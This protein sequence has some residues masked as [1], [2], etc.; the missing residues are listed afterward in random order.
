MKK[1]L[2]TFSLLCS[3][4]LLHADALSEASNA[5]S[6]LGSSLKGYFG[7]NQQNTINPLATGGVISSVDGK[8]KA[9]VSLACEESKTGD[10]LNIDYTG[11]SDINI[12]MKID[13]NVDGNIDN[14]W[15]INN[16]SGICT[17]G[18]VKCNPNSWNNCKYYKYSYTGNLNIIEAKMSD[19]NSCYCINASCGSLSA[20]NKDKILND[21][22][23]YIYSALSNDTKLVVS[24]AIKSASG[25]LV[26]KG[27]DYSMCDTYG[28]VK[29]YSSSSDLESL[30]RQQISKDKQD[31]NS[32]Y[33][34]FYKGTD[35]TFKDQ[36]VI[37]EITDKSIKIDKSTK[38][39]VGSASASITYTDGTNTISTTTQ[40]A[41]KVEAK[42]CEVRVQVTDTS[43]FTDGSNRA[44]ATNNTVMYKN[45]IRECTDNW[46]KCPVGKNETMKFNCGSINN[47]GEALA[48]ISAVDEASKDMVCSKQ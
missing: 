33:S 6:S 42:Y 4:S 8:T 19:V 18:V 30:A 40:I 1:I 37:N 2:F 47:M 46:T 21:I 48:A 17:N 10:F 12:I 29:H 28:E 14:I 3:Y 39:S 44:N 38:G 45:D 7:S 16:V 34:T 24:K 22:A 13:K 11:T 43:A 32:P 15:N 20:K 26:F 27:Q 31:E 25:G 23:G 35:N 36:S 9:N 41:Q 5:G